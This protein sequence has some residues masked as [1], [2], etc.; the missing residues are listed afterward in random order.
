MTL[1]YIVLATLAGGVLSV[2]IAASL[3]V[4]LLSRVVKNLVSL[5]A[6]VLLGTALL[7]V[8][9]EAFEGGLIALVNEGDSITID[10]HTLKLELNVPAEEIERRRATWVKPAP[11]Y[12]RGVLAKF[13]K[14]AAS[15]SQ[16]AVLD[17]FE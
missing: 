12:T 17:R 16:G 8:M 7:H 15:A 5:S 10:A 4:G 2:L 13:A 3:T 1:T 6:G 11:R 14:N 9:P